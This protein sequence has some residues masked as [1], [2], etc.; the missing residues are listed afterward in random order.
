R[1]VTMHGFALNCD[2]DL[3]DFGRI[4]PCGIADADVTSLSLEAGRRVTIAEALPLVRAHLPVALA[5]VT[6]AGRSTAPASAVPA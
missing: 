5:E 3:T 1:G 4:V 2:P 6:A